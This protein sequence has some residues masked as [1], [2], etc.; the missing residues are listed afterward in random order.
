M[1]LYSLIATHR[2]QLLY[3]H[4]TRVYLSQ[5]KDERTIVDK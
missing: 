4:T 2:N 3:V 5:K 1:S